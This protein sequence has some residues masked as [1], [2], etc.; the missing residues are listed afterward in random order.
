M[1][2]INQ[3]TFQKNARMSSI[4]TNLSRTPIKTRHMS[5]KGKLNPIADIQLRIPPTSIGEHC[6]MHKFLNKTTVA[7]IKDNAKCDAIKQDN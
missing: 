1:K 3:G 6:L 7:T 5:G 4:L 2:L